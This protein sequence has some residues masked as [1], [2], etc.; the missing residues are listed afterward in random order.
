M[1]LREKAFREGG[2]KGEGVNGEG[3]KWGCVKGKA[4]RGEALRGEALK[5]KASSEKALRRKALRA[6]VIDELSTVQRGLYCVQEVASW[7]AD[8]S[9]EFVLKGWLTQHTAG[10]PSAILI[11]EA[12]GKYI[13]WTGSL[14]THSF[15][16]LNTIGIMVL[17][18]SIYP[19]SVNLWPPMLRQV[20]C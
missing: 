9:D 7:P 11:P 13:R 2:V 10:N 14:C 8:D 15:I 6:D 17:Y 20:P 1:S 3:V 19:I 18:Q 5:G 4:L 12:L 16:L